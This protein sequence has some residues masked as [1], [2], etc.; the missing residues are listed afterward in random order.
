M[1][2][3]LS[4]M[5]EEGYEGAYYQPVHS[6]TMNPKAVTAGELYGEVNIYTMEWKDGLMGIMVRT[7]VQVNYQ[8]FKL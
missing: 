3:A 7:A 5:H 6:Y 8:I 4:K 1:D 2:R